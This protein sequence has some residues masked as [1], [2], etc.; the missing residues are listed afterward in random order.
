MT[1]LV[2]V[3]HKEL[4]SQLVSASCTCTR[5]CVYMSLG[6]SMCMTLYVCKC[7]HV[8]EC[9][10]LY[11]H[12]NVCILLCVCVCTS[13]CLCMYEHVCQYISMYDFAHEHAL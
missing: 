2:S 12:S 4:L 9:M 7:L 11:V 1:F 13:L 8:S 3:D 6:I 5:R 10:C